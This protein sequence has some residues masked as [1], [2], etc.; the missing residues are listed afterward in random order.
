MSAQRTGVFKITLKTD[1]DMME[2]LLT[3]N[4]RMFPDYHKFTEKQR[5]SS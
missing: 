5:D 1:N 2:P 3:C 4:G